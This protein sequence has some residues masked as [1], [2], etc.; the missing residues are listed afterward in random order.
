MLELLGLGK[1]GLVMGL[2]VVTV[3]AT[4]LALP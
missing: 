3:L 1:S 4:V 2:G